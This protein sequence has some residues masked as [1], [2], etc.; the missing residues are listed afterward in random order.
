MPAMSREGNAVWFTDKEHGT[1][2]LSALG[3]VRERYAMLHSSEV[4]TVGRCR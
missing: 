4:V 2:L 1:V 3:Q